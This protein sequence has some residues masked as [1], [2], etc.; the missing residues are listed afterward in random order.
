MTAHPP[1]PDY[2]TPPS[3]QRRSLGTWAALLVVWSIGLVSWA[4]YGVAAIY[5]LTK[6]M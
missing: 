2:E 6:V 3:P 5:L 1:T 4:V